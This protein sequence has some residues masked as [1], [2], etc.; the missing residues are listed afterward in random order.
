MGLICKKIYNYFLLIYK[1]I[2]FDILKTLNNFLLLPKDHKSINIP[3][4]KKQSPTL[5]V[6]K[7][8]IELWFAAILVNQK[9]TQRYEQIPTPSHK[10]YYLNM[11]RL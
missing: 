10:F 11:L 4:V 9:F 6:K 3:I 8:D 7:A 5:L 2:C 1:A